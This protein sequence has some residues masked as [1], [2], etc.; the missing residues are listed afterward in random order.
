[1]R[2]ISIGAFVFPLF[3]LAYTA[4]SLGEQ[5]VAGLRYSLLT[6]AL[7]L[8]IPI[9]VLAALVI[10][11]EVRAARHQDDQAA[12]PIAEPP[13]VLRAARLRPVLL[14]GVGLIAL[15]TLEPLGY[16]IAFALF[17]IGTMLTLGARSPLAISAVT[18]CTLSFVH[19][20]FFVWLQLALPVGILEGLI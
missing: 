19:L 10:V 1:M 3:A 4:Y 6:Y 12:R 16:P 5:I 7:C 17:M 11:Q 15:L 14:V 2:R 20:V 8:A 9:F 13:E 18:I